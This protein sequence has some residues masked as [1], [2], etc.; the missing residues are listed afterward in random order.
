VS[1]NIY[2]D[3]HVPAA[4]TRAL[5]RRG[6]DVLIAQED[7][8]TELDDGVLLDRVGEMGRILFTRDEDLLGIAVH[9]LRENRSFA[10]V[11]YAHQ[12]RVTIGE[13]VS[14]LELIS[15]A[16]SPKDSVSHVFFLPL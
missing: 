3:V 8:A 7:G 14:D 2:M 12:I 16:G 5:R 11:V 15:K 1:L 6:I 9:L 4:I 10:T 13:C